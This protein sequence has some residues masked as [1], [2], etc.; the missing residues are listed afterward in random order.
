MLCNRCPLKHEGR[1]RVRDE[2][3]YKSVRGT[4]L[5]SQH[6]QESKIHIHKLISFSNDTLWHGH[7]HPENDHV[8]GSRY[9]CNHP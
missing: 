2:M 6:L 9:G 4:G 8:N 1:A 5:S 7:N 3:L